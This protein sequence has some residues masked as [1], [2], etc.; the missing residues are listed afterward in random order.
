MTPADVHFE[1][2]SSIREDRAR[3]LA[4]AY[5]RNP[6]RFVHRPPTPAALPTAVWINPPADRHLVPAQ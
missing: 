1:R 5:E 3:T 2:A 4:Q 6:E